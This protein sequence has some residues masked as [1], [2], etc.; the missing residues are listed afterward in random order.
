ML[1]VFHSISISSLPVNLVHIGI[2][3]FEPKKK[4]EWRNTHAYRVQYT[5]AKCGAHLDINSKL[6]WTAHI[7][8]S[9]GDRQQPSWRWT[10]L[11]AFASEVICSR[12]WTPQ[13]FQRCRSHRSNS[14]QYCKKIIKAIVFH[15]VSALGCAVPAIQSNSPEYHAGYHTVSQIGALIG[16]LRQ[17]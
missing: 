8:Y 5:H 2:W 6:A 13:C 10:D 16:G 7:E 1:D 12:Q 3:A 4:K 9:Q 11:W 14:R 17:R 15:L